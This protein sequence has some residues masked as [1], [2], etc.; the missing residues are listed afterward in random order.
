MC[1]NIRKIEINIFIIYTQENEYLCKNFRAEEQKQNKSNS[2]I[3]VT[4]IK[5]TW[6]AKLLAS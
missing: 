6:I 3:L 4:E 2:F 5:E 1:I